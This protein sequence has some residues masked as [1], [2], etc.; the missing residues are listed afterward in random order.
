MSQDEYDQCTPALWDALWKRRIFDIQAQQFPTAR[1]WAMYALS[2]G[3]EGVTENHFLTY[4]IE[5]VEPEYPFEIP[6]SA[7]NCTPEQMNLIALTKRLESKAEHERKL[8]EHEQNGI[9]QPSS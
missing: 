3:G 4:P 7:R 8:K 6:E 1:G 9:C 5:E 2:H